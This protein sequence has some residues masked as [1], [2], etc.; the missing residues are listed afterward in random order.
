MNDHDPGASPDDLQ[1]AIE[2]AV[3]AHASQRERNGDPYILHPLRVMGRIADT[4]GR[5]VAV[6]HDVLE[7]TE[8][9]A[10]QLKDAGFSDTVLTAVDCLTRRPG[11]PYDEFVQRAACNPLAR[12]V[13]LADLEDNMDLRR[14]PAVLPKDA[15]RMTR[16]LRAWQHLITTEED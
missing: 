7:D 3:A 12:R 11:E 14:L 9:T 2:I 6:L 5:I 4:A 16:Y 13:K 1:K 10:Q 15:D 8:I